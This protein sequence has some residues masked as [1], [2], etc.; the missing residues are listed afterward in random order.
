MLAKL[1]MYPIQSYFVLAGRLRISLMWLSIHARTC[2]PM[3][4]TDQAR[5][6]CCKCRAGF[7]AKM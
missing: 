3:V 5:E 7:R 1:S 2:T 6:P 4:P